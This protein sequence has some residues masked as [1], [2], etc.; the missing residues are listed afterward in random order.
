M[1][2]KKCEHHFVL[3][4]FG[5]TC[6]KCKLYIDSDDIITRLDYF[7][8]YKE[9]FRKN[10]DMNK[11]SLKADVEND[12][13]VLNSDILQSQEIAESDLK[14]AVEALQDVLILAEDLEQAKGIAKYILSK[15]DH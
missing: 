12:P 1:D 13:I 7:D 3:D 14:L 9:E 11:M 8:F 2:D 5:A 15:L 4:Q 10:K 6:E